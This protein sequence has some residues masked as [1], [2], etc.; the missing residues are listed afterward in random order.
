MP[1]VTIM[2]LM[3]IGTPASSGN[4]SASPLVFFLSKAS[5]CSSA[6]SAE[7]CKNALISGSAA[8]I[9]SK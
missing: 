1:L 2:S 8:S 3:A 4:P 9:T 7:T 5:A 6:I